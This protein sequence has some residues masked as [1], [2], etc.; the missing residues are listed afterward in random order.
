MDKYWRIFEDSFCKQERTQG[1][2]KKPVMDFFLVH[3]LAAESGELVSLSELYAEYKKYTK[4]KDGQ[5]V[6]QEL[7]SLTG[8]AWVQRVDTR[9]PMNFNSHS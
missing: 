1:R 2:I 4:R 6:A 7:A 5:T 8:Y 9:W 3:T